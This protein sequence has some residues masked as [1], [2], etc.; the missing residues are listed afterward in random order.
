DVAAAPGARM[1][2]VRAVDRLVVDRAVRTDDLE[3]LG[4]GLVIVRALL[5]AVLGDHR[6]VGLRD[7]TADLGGVEALVGTDRGQK[8][9]IHAFSYLVARLRG[10]GRLSR[11]ANDCASSR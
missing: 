9:R 8:P 3:D 5:R 4:R 2:A 10:L 11:A 6:E 7:A 1:D